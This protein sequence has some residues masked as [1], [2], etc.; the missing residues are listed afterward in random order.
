MHQV[1]AFERHLHHQ[2]ALI[3]EAGAQ[4]KKNLDGLGKL[5]K[6]FLKMLK[7]FPP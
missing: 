6:K 2:N 5:V 1:C 7:K 3:S 4:E